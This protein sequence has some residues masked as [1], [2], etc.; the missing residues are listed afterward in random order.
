MQPVEWLRAKLGL[1][2]TEHLPAGAALD[3][4]DSPLSG[5]IPYR[6]YYDDHTLMTE[7]GVMIQ[8]VKVA[9]LYHESLSPQQ[10]K[11]FERRRNTLLRNIAAGDRGVFAH[12]VRRQVELYPDGEGKTW[13]SRA[14]NA[15]WRSSLSV[16]PLFIN[17]LYITVVQNPH[18]RGVPGLFDRMM[19]KATTTK[20]SA[21]QKRQRQLDEQAKAL[22]DATAMVVRN[23]GEYGARLLGIQRWPQTEALVPALEARQAVERFGCSWIEFQ[24][25]HGALPVYERAALLDY[26]G[27]EQ[28]E[29]GRFLHYL[30]NLQ[31]ERVPVSAQPLNKTLA[32]SAVNAQLV[33]NTLSIENLH[34]TRAAAVLSMGEWPTS[35]PSR[36]LDD[37]LRLPVEFVVTQ[38]F[39]FT[40]RISAE[41][42]MRLKRRRITINDADGDKEE[43]ADEIKQNLSDLS[44]G[45]AVNG[46]HHLTILV[47]VPAVVDRLDPEGARVKTLDA[48]DA[49]VSRVAGAFV[50]MGVKAV[51]ERFAAETFYLAQLPGQPD[52]YIGR[53]GKIKSSNFAG[54]VSLHNFAIGK[55]DGNLWGP[56]VML[57]ETESL[58]PYL[59]N[60]HREMEGMVAGHM[61]VAASTGAGKTAFVAAL[62][63]MVDKA[64]PRVFWFDNREGAVIF[65]RA[66]G[67][68]Q[69]L[70]TALG[71]TGWNPLQ[72]PDTNE[73]RAYL[74]DL[75][76][77]MRTCYGGRCSADD[78][79]RFQRA[80]SEAYDLPQHERRLRNVAWCFG[81][82]ELGEAMR[83]WHGANGN[84]GAN[85]G[86]FDNEFD[87]IDLAAC[88]H[89]CWE[90]RELIKD[91]VARPELPVV[92]SYP[93]H[94]IE[95]SMTTGEPF[96]I[97][98]DEGQ[99]LV[100]HPFWRDRI[101]NYIMQIRRKNGLLVFIT[102]DVKYF[103]SETDSILKQAATKVFMSNG[104][105]VLEEYL[106]A[107]LTVPQFEYV[108]DTPPEERR[109][110]IRRG[111]ETIKAVFDLARDPRLLK[112]IPVLSANQKAVALMHRVIAELGSDD[113][114]TW[115]PV[116]MDRAIAEDTHNLK[117]K[118]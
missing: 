29:I 21:V 93:F 91:N 105:G 114:E 113:P 12:V 68:R 88:R 115:V 43:D 44:R 63:A 50:K 11:A 30:I 2:L 107:G 90:M 70:L 55:L 77:L 85:A 92:L 95:Q 3:A 97:V 82:G 38:S 81:Q 58:T 110:L 14:F 111:N 40:D 25:E 23:L 18:R 108:R 59:F 19:A 36:M 61:A 35:T 65:M 32:N 4:K 45:R 46:L 117:P 80:V 53:R 16:R 86:V 100:K 49:A 75:L 89:H 56:A 22:H 112:F 79:E 39:F 116:F 73:N 66:M 64:Q 8:V 1:S 78:M 24:R 104:E 33:G 41:Q 28:S 87:N 9:G 74:I 52:G 72:L 118:G 99:N 67:G 60:F 102:P 15:A 69:T 94:R 13:F 20:G 34:G 42:D 109:L 51:R 37:F 17:E 83:P 5:V 47:H 26:I 101:D 84:A 76:V 106:K 27:P 103:Y 6:H 10:I 57:L 98:L 62:A 31:D 54:F 96:I 48:L 7:D 71:T